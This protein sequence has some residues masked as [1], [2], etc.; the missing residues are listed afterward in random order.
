MTRF[1]MSCGL[2]ALSAA[3]IAAQQSFRATTLLV[4]VDT[5]VT[6]GKGQFVTGLTADDFEV[7]EEGKPQK[8][9]RIYVVTGGAVTAALRSAA[10]TGADAPVEQPSLPATSPSRVFVL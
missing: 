7:L 5:I 9:E 2:A 4:E 8:I 3:S 6:D 10:A 1:L